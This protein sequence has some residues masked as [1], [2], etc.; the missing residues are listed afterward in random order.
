MKVLSRI[1]AW[2]FR[3]RM[4]VLL[5]TLLM[6]FIVHPILASQDGFANRFIANILFLL[7]LLGAVNAAVAHTRV[8]WV[9]GMIALPSV[10]LRWTGFFLGNPML[11]HLSFG[12]DLLLYTL[13]TG[14]LLIHLMQSTVVTTDKLRWLASARAT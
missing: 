5:I 13:V 11:A 12:L 9:A 7:V 14:F 8:L 3:E 6:L 1:L 2:L 10:A 4:A